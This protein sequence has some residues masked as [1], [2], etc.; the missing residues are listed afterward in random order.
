[1]KFKKLS[2]VIPCY[3][4]GNKI[5]D[6]LN[7]HIIPFLEDK[8]LSYEIILVNDGSKDNTKEIFQ[9]LKIP[10]V[11]PLGYD[12][13]RGKGGAVKFG[14]EQASGDY[15]VYMDADLSTHLSAFDYL[16][17]EEND[18]DFFVGS[19]HLKE[20]V[21]A[22]KQGLLRR[23]IGRSCRV[24]V[25]TTFKFRYKDT[26]CGFKAI[27]T[28]YAKKMAE[29]QIINGFAFD[30]EYL[31]IAKLNNLKVKQFP[32]IWENDEDS[33]VSA[34]RS[35]VIFFKDVF[36]IKRNNKNYYF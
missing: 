36:K 1:M 18:I 20:S 6:N 28:E 25:N 3:N 9:N 2:I 7:N 29:K 21:L 31:Y 14:I 27:K 30:V 5:V 16:I 10:H 4:E 23:F 12:L 17:A 11:L 13:N 15:V 33:K 32:V 35:S 26:Q 8:K 22:K 19:R 34:F 24:I